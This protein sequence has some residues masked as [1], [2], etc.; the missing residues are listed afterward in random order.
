MNGS[1]TT[2]ITLFR[3]ITMLC[4]TDNIMQNIPH[5]QSKC[6]EYFVILTVKMWNVPHIHNDYEEYSA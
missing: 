5:I 6:D 3:A 2:S 1:S 4:R